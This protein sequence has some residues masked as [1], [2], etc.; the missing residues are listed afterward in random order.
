MWARAATPRNLG[1]N[2]T[3]GP[4]RW[5]DRAVRVADHGHVTREITALADRGL[6]AHT[7][8]VEAMERLRRAIPIDGYCFSTSD[9]ATLCVTSQ[10]TE[11]VDRALGPVVYAIEQDARPD[12]ARHRDLARASTPVRT[13]WQAT[14]GDPSR[15]RRWREVLQPLGVEHELRAAA[16]TAGTTWGFLHLFRAAG[17]PAFDADEAAL[18]A[19]LS[20]LLG[21]AL[22][23]AVLR[24]RVEPVAADEAPQ[25]IVL[26][27]ANRLVELTPGA[28]A[29]VDALREHEPAAAETP[30]VLVNLAVWA[31]VL[32]ASGR[33]ESVRA[34]VA[35]ADGRWQ[36]LHA[37]CTDRGRVVVVAQ[38]APPAEMLP[39]LMSS[40]GLSPGEREV[41]ELA[42]LGRSTKEMAAELVISPYTV[43]DRLKGVFAKVGVRS[44]RDLV[45]RLTGAAA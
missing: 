41:V 34:R 36:V 39:L 40:Y 30:E 24:P 37:A 7:L 26:D 38:G 6:D 8:R 43:Q 17:R 10:A 14:K 20:E 33:P 29:R 15:S 11:G 19:E 5:K 25:V 44:R 28:R 23:D 18:V 3:G 22:R 2:W 1:G 21:R 4:A 31:R 45:A 9:P 32:A 42:L 16:R 27:A 12:A 35:G 13:L